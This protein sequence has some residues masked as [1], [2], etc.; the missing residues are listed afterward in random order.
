MSLSI[1]PQQQLF[2]SNSPAKP[3]KKNNLQLQSLIANLE[4]VHPKIRAEPEQ[5]KTEEVKKELGNEVEAMPGI[6]IVPSAM[7]KVHSDV[8]ASTPLPYINFVVGSHDDSDE[9]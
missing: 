9:Y 4:I 3:R 2:N 8:T 5:A 1:L 6:E 7:R